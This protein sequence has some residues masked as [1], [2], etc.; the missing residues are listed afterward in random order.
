MKKPGSILRIKQF[1]DSEEDEIDEE[2][3][4]NQ[5]ESE[6]MQQEPETSES[7]QKTKIRKK[8]NVCVWFFYWLCS[9]FVNVYVQE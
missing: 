8:G 4:E 2:M 3:E 5:D 6:E 7:K 1:S 9:N